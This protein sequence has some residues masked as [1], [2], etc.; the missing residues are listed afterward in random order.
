MFE[1][2]TISIIAASN[3][4]TIPSTPS[5]VNYF[6][7]TGV[8]IQSQPYSVAKDTVQ[9]SLDGLQNSKFDIIR[10][11]I[12]SFGSLEEN[13]NFYGATP[14]SHKTISNALLVL[15]KL[16]YL[17]EAFPTPRNSV[18]FEYK[19]EK[20][21]L[22]IEIYEKSIDIYVEFANGEEIEQNDVSL[23]KLKKLVTQ[24]NGC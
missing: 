19:T 11:K 6:D 15:D 4:L 12:N 16:N 20:G 18:Q 9:Y 22:E 7:T 21:Y 13:W 17:P 3:I 2:F 23:E 10:K 8:C 24:I 5:N 14:L 1:K